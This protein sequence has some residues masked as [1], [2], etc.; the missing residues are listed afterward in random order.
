MSICDINAE[1]GEDL[2][3]QLSKNVKDRVIFIPCDVTD[4]MQFEGMFSKHF[5]TKL[6]K[7]S[8]RGIPD[9]DIPIG[10]GGHSDK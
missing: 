1:A 9:Y 2:L 4:Y 3:H 10:R 5:D 8:F 7:E 6:P